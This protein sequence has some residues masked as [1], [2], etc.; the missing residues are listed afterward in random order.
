MRFWYETANFKVDG[1]IPRGFGEKKPVLRYSMT[2]STGYYYCAQIACSSTFFFVRPFQ[3]TRKTKTKTVS[4]TEKV[5]DCFSINA[6]K[7]KL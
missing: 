4:F 6:R 2:H 1:F 3:S 5:K 7:L